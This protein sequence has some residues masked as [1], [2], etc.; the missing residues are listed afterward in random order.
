M[1]AVSELLRDRSVTYHVQPEQTVCDAV[2]LM[3]QN[4][5][6]AVAVVRSAELVGIFS[7]RDLM[8]RV[9][10]E[11]RDPRRT[12]IAEVMTV[13]L[14]VVSPDEDVESCLALMNQRG[15][16]HLPV[17]EGRILKGLLSLRDVLA[18]K[19]VE[20]DGEVRMM[21]AYIAQNT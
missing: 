16:R 8:R 6:G 7:E 5:V 17:C 9:V 20:K 19:M 2:H 4:N 1:A 12:S 15:F 18:H 10:A 3:V 21:R 11:N 13:D 14:M